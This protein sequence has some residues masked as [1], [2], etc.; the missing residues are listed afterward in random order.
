MP[1]V[2]DYK[3]TY[4][5]GTSLSGLLPDAGDPGGALTL[6][7]G[8]G[9]VQANRANI[10]SNSSVVQTPDIGTADYTARVVVRALTL[11]VNSPVFETRNTGTT[12]FFCIIG[13]ANEIA[14]RY[15]DGSTSNTV[16]S[17]YAFTPVANTD[18]TVEVTHS[19][20]THTVKL[21]GAT[22]IGPVS[23]TGSNNTVGVRF[24]VSGA[25]STSTTGWHFDRVTVE[26][27][28]GGPTPAPSFGRY[29]VRGPVR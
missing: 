21:D 16:G 27:T 6:T 18:Y 5:N 17:A 13:N 24:V 25:G 22:I 8:T 19:G 11:G 26:T 2:Q 28:A 3:F 12:T 15:F 23:Y 10:T 14:L 7:G 20:N 9:E 1:I 4:A 29:G